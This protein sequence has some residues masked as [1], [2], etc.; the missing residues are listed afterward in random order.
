MGSCFDDPRVYAQMAVIVWARIGSCHQ[1]RATAADMRNGR[2]A[3][4]GL[5]DQRRESGVVRVAACLREV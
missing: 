2:Q 1:V 3:E 5:S 4:E